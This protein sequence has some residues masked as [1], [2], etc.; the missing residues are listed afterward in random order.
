MAINFINDHDYVSTMGME[1]LAGRDFSKDFSTDQQHAFLI[2]ESAAE[3]LG[4]ESPINQ[5][6]TLTYH[7]NGQIVKSGKVIGLVKNFHFN[8][9]H[10]NVDP[11][12]MHIS[13]PTYYTNVLHVRVAGADLSG[14]LDQIE[15]KWEQFNPGRPLEYEFMDEV[16]DALYRK[17]ESLG[18]VAGVFSLIAICIACLGLFGLAAFTVEHRTQE[19]GI[20]KVLGA[21]AANIIALMSW[22]FL[23][24]VL[25]AFVLSLPI[26]LLFYARLAGW[27]CI[28]GKSRLVN[29]LVVRLGL[30]GH[31]F[32]DGQFASI[33]GRSDQPGRC[34]EK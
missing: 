2:N 26:N 8:S 30:P 25:I 24:L 13:G 23:K 19:I 21:S 12:I 6:L 7:F 18:K 17:E 1:I 14:T 27:F 10:K 20:R 29:F 31:S 33:P 28:Q 11:V 5:E 4:W 3:K 34:F 15:D 16:F 22:D 32:L 9:L